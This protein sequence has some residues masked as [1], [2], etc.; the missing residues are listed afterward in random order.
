MGTKHANDNS[1]NLDRIVNAL[2]YVKG[3]VIVVSAR[4]NRLKSDSTLDELRKLIEFYGGLV[5]VEA[6]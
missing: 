4:A 5:K 3:N 6:A 2:G 1:P